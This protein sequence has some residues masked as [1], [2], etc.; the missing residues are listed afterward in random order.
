MDHIEI[1]D[2]IWEFSLVFFNCHHRLIHIINFFLKM[3]YSHEEKILR[4]FELVTDPREKKTIKEGFPIFILITLHYYVLFKD[5]NHVSGEKCMS[6]ILYN[7][8]GLPFHKNLNILHTCMFL[9][10]DNILSISYNYSIYTGELNDAHRLTKIKNWIENS[11]SLRNTINKCNCHK[12]LC[13]IFN[14]LKKKSYVLNQIKNIEIKKLSTI[15]CEYIT[16]HPKCIL[17]NLLSTKSLIDRKS[18]KM[19]LLT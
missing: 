11:Y 2:Y 16:T 8:T 7:I 18:L 3:N 10:S 19:L 15:V 17:F 4:L 14:L 13:E 5:L 1:F 12:E 9:H 6:H